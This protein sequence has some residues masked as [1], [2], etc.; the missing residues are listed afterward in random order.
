MAKRS[1]SLTEDEARL[2]L[3]ADEDVELLGTDRFLPSMIWWEALKA[4]I[5]AP[6]KNEPMVLAA[7]AAVGRISGYSDC[8]GLVGVTRHP[9]PK[10]SANQLFVRYVRK[11]Q[12]KPGHKINFDEP[13]KEIRKLCEEFSIVMLAY[14][15][16]QLHDMMTTLASENIVWTFDFAQAGR[17]LEAD[18]QLQD[19][20]LEKR[21]WHD[22]NDELREH[23]DNADKKLTDDGRKLRI[24]KRED[25]LKIDLA[26]CLSMASYE[27]LRLNL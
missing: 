21:L 16:H 1:Q 7:D 5:S 20:I 18:R 3:E 24:V 22:G 8:F 19:L 14:D 2:L 15:R 12:A 4:S 25:A 6:G 10:Y 11:W 27:C 17:R 23:I 9:D 26:V 13:R